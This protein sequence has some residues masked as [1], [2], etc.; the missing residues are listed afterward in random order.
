MGRKPKLSKEIKVKACEEY[1]NN[2][3]SFISIAKAY[4]VNKESL[5]R[6]Y[7]SYL[8]HGPDVFDYSVRNSSYTKEI[9]IDIVKQYLPSEYSTTDLQ[10]KY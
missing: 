9:K 10:V 4:G 5:R 2:Q 8:N 7:Y 1:K 6:W 3:G